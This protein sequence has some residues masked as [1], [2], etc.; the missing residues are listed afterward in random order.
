MRFYARRIIVSLLLNASWC[1]AFGA[2]ACPVDLAANEGYP[3]IL[4]GKSATEYTRL[5]GR[6]RA[7]GA[8]ARITREKVRQPFFSVPG[9]ILKV[10]NEA[11]QVLAYSNIATAESEA[12]RVSVDGKTIGNSKPSWM[13][14]PHFFKSQ[15]MI[16]IYVGDDQTI[17]KTLQ[18]VMGHQFAGG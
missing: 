11:V 2:Y 13:S 8:T 5:I 14:T 9:R 18:A 7:Q 1:F 6:L 16:V 10:N 3:F 12:K 4:V 17:L 15:K